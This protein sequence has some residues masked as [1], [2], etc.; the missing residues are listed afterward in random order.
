MEG[1]GAAYVI[2]QGFNDGREADM[3]NPGTMLTS[4][5]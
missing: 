2:W 1:G 3:H 5:A 4:Y